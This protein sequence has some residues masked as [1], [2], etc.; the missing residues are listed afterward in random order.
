LSP[1]IVGIIREAT[2][3]FAAALLFL[4]GALLLG[5]LIALLFGYA[6]RAHATSSPRTASRDGAL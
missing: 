6:Q 2:G 1:T 5:G 4:A 3:S